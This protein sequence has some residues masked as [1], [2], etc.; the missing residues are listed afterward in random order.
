MAGWK[1]RQTLFH[2]SFLAPTGGPTSTT[3]VDWHL[4]VK[5]KE[6]NIALTKITVPQSACKKSAQLINSFLRYSRFYGLM[7]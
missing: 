4:K 5:D 7:N 6:Y 1:D 2:R 3:A